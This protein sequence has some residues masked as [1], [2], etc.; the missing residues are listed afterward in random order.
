MF[1]KQG[2]A[3]T[4]SVA[5]PA[6][7]LLLGACGEGNV[8]PTDVD[9]PALAVGDY[10]DTY[11][12]VAGIV[13]VCMF[14]PADVIYT[15]TVQATFSASATGG[16]VIA[17]DFT[18]DNSPPLCIEAW[19]ATSN[20]TES[21]SAA[22]ESTSAGFSLERIV[23]LSGDGSSQTLT[24][25]SSAT[26]LA[27][28]LL[29]AYIWFKLQREDTPPGGGEGCTPGYWRQS[30]HFDSWT[31][32][33]DPSDLFSSVFADAFPGQTLLDV[34]WARGGG[35]DA[36]GRHAVAALLNAASPDVEYDYTAAQVISLFNDAYASG[37]RQTIEDQKT[38]FD[39]LNN[40]G[41]GLN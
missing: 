38:L 19:N 20:V 24:G 37:N 36:L 1:R 39:V 28:D 12:S 35:L 40:Q 3:K 34:V 27:S 15:E 33:Y 23:T 22:L 4:M 31:A 29:G 41:C 10:N 9:G 30:Q 8:F 25:T 18:L 26:V 32:P 2:W 6:A 16:D 5:V 7:A 13:N 21:V 11:S 14:P 17:G